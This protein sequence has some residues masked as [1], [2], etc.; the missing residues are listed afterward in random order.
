MGTKSE[1]SVNLYLRRGANLSQV[2]SQLR[3]GAIFPENAPNQ[4][5]TQQAFYSLNTIGNSR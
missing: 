4:L 3:S 5:S 2:I 1:R